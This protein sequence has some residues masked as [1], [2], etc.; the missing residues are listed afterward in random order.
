M[1][2]SRRSRCFEP[3]SLR[4]PGQHIYPCPFGHLSTSWKPLPVRSAS[5][6]GSRRA[7]TPCAQGC[8]ARA[9]RPRRRARR[10]RQGRVDWVESFS[11]TLCSDFWRDIDG[12]HPV[13][14]ASPGTPRREPVSNKPLRYSS[15]VACSRHASH[16][17]NSGS[18]PSRP[19][20]QPLNSASLTMSGKIARLA[21]RASSRVRFTAW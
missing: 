14:E 6:V 8:R 4:N 20:K 2:G 9:C 7:A 5:P 10:R 13:R 1:G 15:S 17:S 11:H 16:S 18:L 21:S 12:R 3:R 19:R